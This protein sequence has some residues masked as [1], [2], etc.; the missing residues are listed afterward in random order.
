MTR[1][2]KIVRGSGDV[3]RDLGFR[4][5]EARNLAIKPPFVSYR[6]RRDLSRTGALQARVAGKRCCRRRQPFASGYQHGYGAPVL[7]V[8]DVVFKHKVSFLELNR[9]N[10]LGGGCASEQ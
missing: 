6:M 8:S 9:E 7:F 3:F 4:E 1:R 10:D 5:P 2:V